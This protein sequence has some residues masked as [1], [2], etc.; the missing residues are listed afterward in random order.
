MRKFKAIYADAVI[1]KGGDNIVESNLPAMKTEDELVSLS[2]DRY[3]S[4]M[5]RRVFQ[6]G[7]KH[8]MVN[9]KWPA[10][11]KVFFQFDPYDVA[12]M[13]DEALESLM[14]DK[15]IIR[16]FGKIKSVRKN[17]VMVVDKIKAFGRFGSYIASWPS[18]NV[19][20]LWKQLKTEGAQLGG[21]SGA[22]FLRMVG[23]DTF[24]LTDDVIKMLVREEVVEKSPT[25]IKELK[26]VQEAFNCWVKESGRP[27]CEVSR[28]LSFAA[29]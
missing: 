16:H 2:N 20:G 28:I 21:K 26:N 7:L 14:Q 24:M 29:G 12:M 1:K 25:S 22:N 18:S 23:K 4:T 8:S 19:V 11:E 10:F 5:S 13:S 3:L 17:A 15:S 9:N 27:Y 6:A